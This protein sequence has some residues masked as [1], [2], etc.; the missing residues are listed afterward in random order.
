M[1]QKEKGSTEVRLT[2]VELNPCERFKC[3]ICDVNVYKRWQSLI[4]VKRRFK[5]TINSNRI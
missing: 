5:V 3:E 2:I 1:Q 4:R